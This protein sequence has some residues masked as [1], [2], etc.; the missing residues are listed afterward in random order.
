VILK[1]KYKRL[2]MS[3]RG[4]LQNKL[5]EKEM[6]LVPSSFDII[7]SR[8]KAVA[9]I[10]LDDKIKKKA[11]IIARA[12]MQQHKNV[13][14]VLLKESARKGKYR[15]RK[16][17]I[18]AGKRSTEIIHKESGCLLFLDPR[19]V[20]FSPR[21][22][23]ERLRIAEK[24]KWGEK[25]MVFFAGIGPFPI[26]ISKKSRAEKIVGIEENPVAFRYFRKNIE[27]NKASNVFADESDVKKAAKKYYNG[28]DRVIMPL[29]EK[30]V[31]FLYEALKC[32]R[33]EGI[34]HLYFFSKESE[35]NIWKKRVREII[36]KEKRKCKIH[37]IK[38]V[39]PYGPRIYKYR[40]DIGVF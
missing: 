18:I 12:L 21:E 7:G 26:I 37:E 17:R 39:L 6:T 20:Y 9:V 28:F 34:V 30:A 16:T 23:T 13:V 11:K 33:E 27:K 1:V 19:K 4:F 40:M 29:P 35:L 32:L 38:K 25:V 2:F 10:E 22:G 15:I 8:E 24:I 5:K 14:S 3:L 31:E 36:R